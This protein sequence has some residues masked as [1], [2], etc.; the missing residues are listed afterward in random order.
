MKKH[1]PNCCDLRHHLTVWH[2]KNWMHHQSIHSKTTW[3]EGDEG[4]W[5]N[6]WS[7]SAMAARPVTE[8]NGDD[9]PCEESLT[10]CSRTWWVTWQAITLDGNDKGLR[11]HSNKICKLRFNTD[12]KYFSQLES[13]TDGT[14][15]TRTLLMHSCWTVS[16]IDWIKLD[17][18]GCVSSWTS[19]LKPR[20]CHVG[21]QG[22]TR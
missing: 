2:R 20:P 15:Y 8:D 9:I 16:K 6:N 12:I 7:S 18:Q 19:P 21:W 4:R 22:R 14:A 11:G 3:R 10:R 5:T 1:R 17:A 13:L